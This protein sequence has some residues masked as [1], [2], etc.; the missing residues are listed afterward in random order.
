MKR[1]VDGTSN[2]AARSVAIDALM[3]SFWREMAAGVRAGLVK[4]G[5]ASSSW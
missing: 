3:A 4:S 5:G 2:W 1:R